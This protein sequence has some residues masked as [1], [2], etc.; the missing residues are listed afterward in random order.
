MRQGKDKNLVS[1]LR[2]EF[3]EEQAFHYLLPKRKFGY[4]APQ[5]IPISLASYFNQSLLNFNQY[6]ASDADY[7][8]LPGLYMS[9]TTYVHQ[10]N[11]LSTKL[12]QVHAQQ[13]DLKVTLK[14]QLKGLLQGTMYFHL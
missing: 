10:E 14:E 12:N 1:I 13:N 7:I 3:C 6:F 11:L 9:S 8:F 2:N 4:K 5:D